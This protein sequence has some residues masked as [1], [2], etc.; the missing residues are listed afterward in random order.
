MLNTNKL[1]KQIYHVWFSRY[2]HIP[3]SFYDVMV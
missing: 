1:V 3:I 2:W